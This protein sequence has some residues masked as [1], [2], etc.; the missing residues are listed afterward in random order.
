MIA[1]PRLTKQLFSTDIFVNIGGKPFQIQR[2][3]FSAPGDSPNY[4]SLGFA[5]FFSTPSEAFPGLDRDALLR[6][7]G[8]GYALLS[9]ESHRF[10]PHVRA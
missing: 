9:V 3:L 10:Y 6:L 1:V 5:H 7:F 8:E 4:F 2:D